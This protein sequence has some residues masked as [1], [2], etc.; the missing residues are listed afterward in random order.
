MF[1]QYEDHNLKAY[2]S[3]KYKKFVLFSNPDKT[4]AKLIVEELPNQMQNPFKVLKLWVKWEQLDIM[5]MIEAI[6]QKG[7]QEALRHERNMK[8]VK[9][10]KELTKL[11]AGKN[12]FKSLLMSK[13]SKVNRITELTRKIQDSEKQLECMDV[14]LKMVAIQQLFVAVPFFKRDK[15]ALYNDLVST[16]SN[17]QINN[18]N[19][20][21]ACYSKLHSMNQEEFG[22]D[23]AEE[24]KPIR[25]DDLLKL[26]A[27]SEK[28]NKLV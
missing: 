22:D 23:E 17:F 10:E 12:T 6:E 1:Q 2:I 27:D 26:A 15:V 4:S 19:V 11:S 16:Y 14:Y 13:N 28:D 20:I 25:M 18:A 5:A 8:K 3:E 7:V 9:R 24:K 21:S